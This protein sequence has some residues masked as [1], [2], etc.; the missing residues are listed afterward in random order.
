MATDDL[1]PTLYA[2]L[3][4]DRTAEPEVIEAAYRRLAQKYHPDVNPD[5]ASAE[6][7]RQINAAYQVLRDPSRRATYDRGLA[8][9]H[10]PQLAARPAR[11]VARPVG[12]SRPAG[13]G[14]RAARPPWWQAG[15]G[16]GLSVGAA[17]VIFVLL[18]PEE[19]GVDRFGAGAISAPVGLTA[20]ALRGEQSNPAS[21]DHSQ[22]STSPTA[23]A[24]PTRSSLGL[25]ASQT[26]REPTVERPAQL[27]TSVE[28]TQPVGPAATIAATAGAGAARDLPV[29]LGPTDAP[30]AETSAPTPERSARAAAGSPAR[31]C[32][33]PQRVVV[34]GSY[35]QPERRTTG[36]EYLAIGRVQNTCTYPLTARVEIAAKTA[37]LTVVISTLLRPITLGPGQEQLFR[38]SI[39]ERRALDI[40]TFG[41]Q[42]NVAEPAP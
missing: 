8:A 37:D 19:R 9:A 18:D 24:E 14:R 11:P 23:I 13:P 28:T 12:P 34:L 39:G 21:N 15:L 17:L 22:P 30:L 29:A 31:S 38:E 36:I 16:L 4:V 6:R 1:S 3:Q 32:S 41:V 40:Y 42:A 7:M 26:P 10:G 35:L 2:V 5:R 25:A 27:P 33:N 20:Q